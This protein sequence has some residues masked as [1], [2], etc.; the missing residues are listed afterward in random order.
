LSE[1][2]STRP[3]FLAALA[4][5]IV[6]GP[7]SLTIFIPAL[8]AVQHDFGAAVQSV[9]L[10]LSLPLIAV[11]VAPALG[12][13]LS[14]RL[15]RRPVV[16]AS[17]LV[18]LA[19][20][21]L[22]IAAR[23][24]WVLIVGRV[25]VGVSGTCALVVARAIIRDVFEGDRL[26]RAMARFSAVPVAAI[27]LAPLLGGVV[28][29]AHGWRAV[30]VVLLAVAV[31]ITVF[32]HWGLPETRPEAVGSR[33]IRKGAGDPGSTLL[34][35]AVFWGYAWQSAF[36]FAIAL[37]FVAAAPYLMVNVLGRSATDYGIGLV[38]VVAG[39]LAGVLAA[40]RLSGRFAI[41]TMVF[42]G[43]L[44]GAAAST[45]M[46]FLLLVTEIP[47]SPLLLFVPATVLAFAIGFAMPASQAGIV[48]TVPQLSGTASGVSSCLQMLLAAVFSHVVA[49]PWQQPYMAL[50]ILSLA[51]MV[52]AAACASVPVMANFRW[53]GVADE[54]DPTGS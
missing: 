33:E 4:G 49:L 6:I 18:L 30:F 13:G 9:Q 17:L 29:D 41:P 5:I 36:H 26:A 35:S 14:D 32:V 20:C 2:I 7:L 52:L 40:E 53:K 37:G 1:D 50:G 48:D 44:F 23:E 3:I 45:V 34:R 54:R 21:V 22:C 10:S 42:A 15:G 38:A 19:S 24:L 27:L 16:V 31:T 39:M 8:P 28:T 47:D 12:G 46:P 11:I 51:A 43:C 25:I